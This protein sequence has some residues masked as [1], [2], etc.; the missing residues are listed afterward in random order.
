MHPAQPRSAA[1][2]SCHRRPDGTVV[3]R[4]RG[5]VDVDSRTAVRDAFRFALDLVPS[6]CTLVVDLADLAFCDSTGLNALL[7]LRHDAQQKHT[8]MVLS[9]PG[10]QFRRLLEV[11]GADALWTVHPNIDA[12]VRAAASAP[13]PGLPPHEPEAR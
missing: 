2:F 12:A 8:H 6:H 1:S 9:G 7:R 11:T 13:R 10:R 5:H 3:C 4:V